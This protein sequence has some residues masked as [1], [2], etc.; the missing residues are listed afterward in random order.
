V[1]PSDVSGLSRIIVGGGIGAGKGVVAR[2]LSEFG[3][4]VISADEV[5]HRVLEPGGTAFDDVAARWPSVVVDGRVDRSRLAGIVF[6]DPDEL[7]ELEAM[8]H[9]AISEAIGKRVQSIAG[10]V[11]VEVPVLLPLEN[12]WH[13]VFVDAAEET[14][15]ER[16][17]TRGDEEEEVRRRAA[18]QADR[19]T[20]F[21]WADDVLVNEGSIEDLRAQVEELVAPSS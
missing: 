18:A 10:P 7:Q 8:T 15:V 9:G 20:W 6:R 21:E 14:R 12:G 13:R 11:V 5:G 3:Y 17:V 4:E 19:N 16:A 1:I 2:I